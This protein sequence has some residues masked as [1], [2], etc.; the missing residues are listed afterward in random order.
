MVVGTEPIADCVG[1]KFTGLTFGAGFQ[2]RNWVA[3]L[4]L[5]VM[6]A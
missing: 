3:I 4:M 5:R 1:A 6:N 2:D